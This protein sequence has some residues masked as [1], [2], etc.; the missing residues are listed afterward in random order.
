MDYKQKHQT[1]QNIDDTDSQIM[2][3]IDFELREKYNQ[4]ICDPNDT[5]TTFFSKIEQIERYAKNL[6]FWAMQ[7]PII[8]SFNEI[9]TNKELLLRYSYTSNAYNDIVER[10]NILFGDDPNIINDIYTYSQRS[11][12]FA[13]I[14]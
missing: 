11:D 12:L 1:Y 8:S 13:H 6:A 7:R 14:C 4:Y 5:R 3:K 10:I 9:A 2:N